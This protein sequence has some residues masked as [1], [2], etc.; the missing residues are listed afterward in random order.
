MMKTLSPRKKTGVIVCAISALS[1]K[2]CSGVVLVVVSGTGLLIILFPYNRDP[3]QTNGQF[4]K[5]HHCFELCVVPATTFRIKWHPLK[6]L[7]HSHPG[8]HLSD[9]SEW[10]VLLCV[11]VHKTRT[12]CIFFLLLVLPRSN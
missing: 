1:S 10:C 6:A 8:N 2:N 9:A 4:C 11:A 7:Y 3:I 12:M 5:L